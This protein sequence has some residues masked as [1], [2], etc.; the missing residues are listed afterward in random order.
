MEIQQ[1][2]GVVLLATYVRR[3]E[4]QLRAQAMSTEDRARARALLDGTGY[5]EK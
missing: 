3:R 5:E 1:I 2:I 4:R